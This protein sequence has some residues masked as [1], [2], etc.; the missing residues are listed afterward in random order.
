MAGD[1]KSGAEGRYL[2]SIV[3]A[4]A[5]D[6][7]RLE[8]EGI[9][10]A[11]VQPLIEGELAAIVS[12]FPRGELRPERKNLAAHSEVLR[13]V[14]EQTSLLPVAFGIV[15]NS[16]RD[17]RKLLAD[18]E[19]DLKEQLAGVEGKVE[20]SLRGKLSV[21]NVFQ[22]F[23]GREPELRALRDETF[24]NG[25][26]SREA[27][28]ELGQAFAE[29]LEDFQDERAAQV[30]KRVKGVGDVRVSD[31]RNEEEVLNLS[32]LVPKDEVQRLA[33]T[34]EELAPEL[35][36]EIELQLSGPWPPYDFVDLRIE[37][38]DEEAEAEEAR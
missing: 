19:K 2:Y 16:E 22:Y 26:P 1:E 37:S 3:S 17:V 14:M 10:G 38:E 5:V 33:E 35:E 32:V 12:P 28:I 13:V 29:L 6:G 24:A 8:V 18:H 11:E 15:A 9:E 20:M 4:K 34:V 31:P 23:V 36:D 7:L 21:P 30:A 27:R 25:E